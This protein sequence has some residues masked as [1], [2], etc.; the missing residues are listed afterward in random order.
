[1]DDSTD[2]PDSDLPVVAVDPTLPY[3]T[4]RQDALHITHAR[5]SKTKLRP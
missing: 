1:M 4:I 5:L 2:A 3:E